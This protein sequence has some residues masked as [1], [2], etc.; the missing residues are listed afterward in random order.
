MIR[1]DA[2]LFFEGHL[3]NFKVTRLKKSL[4]LN[5]IG[6][7][8]TVTPVWIHQW[9]RNDG[10]AW[11]SIE[12]V[13]YCFWRSSVK[14]QGH[15]AKKNRRFWPKLGFLDRKIDNLNPIWVRLLGRS[16]LSNPSDLPCFNTLR[17]RQDGRHFAD[18]VLKCIFMNENV[19]ISLKIPLKFVPRGP[20]NNIPALVQIMA[21]RRPG[22]RPLSEPML[23]FVPTHICVTRPQWVNPLGFFEVLLSTFTVFLAATKQLYEWFS[24]SVCPS[25]RLSVCHTFLTMFRSSYHHEIFGSYYQWQKWR[26]CK[27]SRSEVKGQGHRGHKPT[28]P[29]PNCNSSLNSRMIMKWCI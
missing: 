26:P 3:S 1:R 24:P 16:Q 14:F 17:P 22:D 28:L 2:L 11:S 20:I 19:W 29:F 12:E 18:D 13:P 9:L 10:K 7:F 25:V 21:W 4:I 5:Q 15:S 6:R 23:V 8:R 27:R